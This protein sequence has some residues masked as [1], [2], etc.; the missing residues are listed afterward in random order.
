[1]PEEAPGGKGVE[2]VVGREDELVGNEIA[3]LF[4]EGGRSEE[5][6]MAGT[7]SVDA[8]MGQVEERLFDGAP[9]VPHGREPDGRPV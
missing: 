7:E 9:I 2:G 4:P 8:V 1:M 5:L 3:L 6:A